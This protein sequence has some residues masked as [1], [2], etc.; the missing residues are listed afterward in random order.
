MKIL[1]CVHIPCSC[2][3]TT[4]YLYRMKR[5]IIAVALVSVAAL[6]AA[7]FFLNQSNSDP[8]VSTFSMVA[9]DPEN[10]DLGVVVQS[11]FPNLRPVVPWARA[12]VGAV[13]TQSFA[14]LDYGIKG[15]DLMEN[16]A[17]AEEA[18]RIVLRGDDGREDRQVGVVDAHGNAAT[19][20]GSGVKWIIT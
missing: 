13:A 5:S 9:F 16:G 2:E 1:P 10:G 6:S 18:L 3:L 14:E 11:K 7:L 19:W 15:L 4:F 17:T 12:G 8:L 20:T